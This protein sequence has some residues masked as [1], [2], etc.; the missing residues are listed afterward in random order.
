MEVK[1]EHAIAIASTIGA[2]VLSV[3]LSGKRLGKMEKRL[4]D[5]EKK[6]LELEEEFRRKIEELVEKI[7]TF[8]DRFTGLDGEPR[9]L[10]AT[11]QEKIQI[12][13][14]MLMRQ[15]LD[16]H[17]KNIDKLY[18]KIDA[19]NELLVE[20]L[21]YIVRRGDLGGDSIKK[22]LG[23]RSHDGATEHVSG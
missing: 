17:D 21:P 3:F 16:D 8:D 7:D 12:A 22:T 15:R 19:L 9:F 18:R 20:I 10:T 5:G 2:F 11:A 13:C 6:D 1:L 23:K 4:D 14:Q